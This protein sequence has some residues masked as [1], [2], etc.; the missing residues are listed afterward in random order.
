MITRKKTSPLSGAGAEI[1]WESDGSTIRVWWGDTGFAIAESFVTVVLED[2]FTDAQRW[3][4]LGAS[5]TEPVSGG[6]GEFVRDH[7]MLTPRHASALAAIM[8][9]DGLLK[10]RGRKPIELRRAGA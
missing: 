2:F 3:Y 6:L 9:A 10:Y 5:M 7:S 8:V 1:E 4:P